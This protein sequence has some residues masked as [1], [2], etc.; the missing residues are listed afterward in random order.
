MTFYSSNP[1]LHLARFARTL[2]DLIVYIM[3]VILA[4]PAA[5]LLI[6]S[7]FLPYSA[8]DQLPA[9]T[10]SKP[11]VEANAP[12]MWV[13]AAS[14]YLGENITLHFSTPHPQYLGVVNPDGKF[15]YVVFPESQA[16]GTLSPLVDSKKFAE[17][18]RL[19]ITPATLKADP[20]IYG[21]LEN[22]PVFTKSGSYTFILGDNLHIDDPSALYKVKINYKHLPRPQPK[23]EVLP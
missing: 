19:V 9:P 14:C 17:L 4:I 22:R 18:D 3:K 10:A 21:I 16:V 11:P 6:S 2:T 12:S 7:T 8:S 5:G 15:F 1:Q 20:Y 13:D 23:T